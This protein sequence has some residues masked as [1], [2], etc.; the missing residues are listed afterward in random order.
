[1]EKTV[2]DVTLLP[3]E[4][5][6][7]VLEVTLQ[8]RILTLLFIDY[9]HHSHFLRI[10][11]ITIMT[12]TPPPTPSKSRSSIGKMNPSVEVVGDVAV[13]VGVVCLGTSSRISLLTDF[14]RRSTEE[15]IENSGQERYNSS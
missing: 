5:R 8:N 14:S 11:I 12:T 9:S 6:R 7:H 2:S 13:V 10:M 4:P 3:T 15:Q 1:M